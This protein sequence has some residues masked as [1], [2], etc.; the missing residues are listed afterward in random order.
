MIHN[1]F[2]DFHCIYT[3]IEVVHTEFIKVAGTEHSAFENLS[4]MSQ[5]QAE[6]AIIIALISKKNKPRKMR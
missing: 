6:T 3:F 1:R 4:K 5:E 2:S